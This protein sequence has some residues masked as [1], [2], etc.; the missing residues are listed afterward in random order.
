M[1]RRKGPGPKARPVQG[2]SRSL[3][4][5]PTSA[6][7]H[8]SPLM[9]SQGSLVTEDDEALA[10]IYAFLGLCFVSG[11][12]C[13]AKS[14]NAPKPSG[15]ECESWQ[16]G[17]EGTL[18][19]GS[20]CNTPSIGLSSLPRGSGASGRDMTAG[21]QCSS[22]RASAPM[23]PR[24]RLWRTWQEVILFGPPAVIQRPSDCQ[25]HW[26]IGSRTDGNGSKGFPRRAALQGA[27]Q[28]AGWRRGP[29]A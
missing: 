19:G 22:K 29:K 6:R 10:M 2:G 25:A 23:R 14:P 3:E 5:V 28:R 21:M 24:C 20:T 8:A 11:P 16:G 27:H 1:P 4:D 15:L 26:M 18:N 7:D 17:S 13:A 9:P 12:Q